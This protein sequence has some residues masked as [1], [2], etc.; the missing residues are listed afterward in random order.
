MELIATGLTIV[1]VIVTVVAIALPLIH[2]RGEGDGS[3][4]SNELSDLGRMREARNEALTAVMDLDDE[5]ERGNI[6]LA[7]YRVMRLPLVRRAAA[8]I[9]EIEGREQV[10]DEEIERA[11]QMR[12][13]R[14]AEAEQPTT[15]DDSSDSG[16]EQ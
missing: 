6:T 11:V 8:L 9:R 15:P 1:A 3:A 12:R 5:L 2:T 4:E 14:I 13:E 16:H 7:E 10:L